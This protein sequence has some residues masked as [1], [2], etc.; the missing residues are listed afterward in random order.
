MKKFVKGLLTALFIVSLVCM[1]GTNTD[2]PL[3]KQVAWFLS[4][5]TICALSGY[6]L[7]KLI[8]E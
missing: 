1:L 2:L 4:C 7:N 3:V 6:G 5:L 8:A